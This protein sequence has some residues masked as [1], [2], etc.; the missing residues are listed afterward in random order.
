M[1]GDHEIP[2]IQAE[3]VDG[4]TWDRPVGHRGS[5][6]ARHELLPPP[7]VATAGGVKTPAPHGAVPLDLGHFRLH[8]HYSTWCSRC[9][10]VA[11]RRGCQ[12]Q[13]SAPGA[14]P[15]FR[16]PGAEPVIVAWAEFPSAMWPV[17]PGAG[18]S[19]PAGRSLPGSSWACVRVPLIA[20]ILPSPLVISPP[21]SKRSRSKVRRLHLSH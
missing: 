15:G 5:H 1:V 14:S 12:G 4:G 20:G 9:R 6:G 13:P 17:W 19:L 3:M 16:R 11:S 18:V 2:V 7:G 8:K 10:A 21:H